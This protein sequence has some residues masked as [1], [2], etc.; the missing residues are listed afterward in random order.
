MFHRTE[1]FA[2]QV[3]TIKLGVTHYRLIKFILKA[4][5]KS[6][7]SLLDTTL[8]LQVLKA[9]SSPTKLLPTKTL[10]AFQLLW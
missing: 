8:F 7:D 4:L 1:S 3:V 6:V 5:F 9:Y 10:L 2:G